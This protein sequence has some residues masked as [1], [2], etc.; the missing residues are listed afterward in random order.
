MLLA[1]ATAFK[2]AR[3]ARAILRTDSDGTG[4]PREW[5]SLVC[6]RAHFPARSLLVAVLYS[7]VLTVVVAAAPEIT[8]LAAM[9]LRSEWVRCVTRR[10]HK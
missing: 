6:F 8:L 3:R 5:P 4:G 9:V 1:K 2:E 7:Q 10:N